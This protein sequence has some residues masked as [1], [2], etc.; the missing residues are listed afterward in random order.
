MPGSGLIR[1]AGSGQARS[2]RIWT[3]QAWPVGNIG[4]FLPADLYSHVDASRP[5]PFDSPRQ[6]DF[7]P[8]CPDAVRPLIE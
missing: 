6:A 8:L 2:G 1:P 5:I 3:G 7:K 4:I